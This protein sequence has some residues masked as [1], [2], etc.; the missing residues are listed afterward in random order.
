MTFRCSSAAGSRRT[1]S[2]SAGDR[3]AERELALRGVLRSRARDSRR[4][5]R[6]ARHPV[7]HRYARL[8][9]TVVPLTI[10]GVVTPIATASTGPQFTAPLSWG[11]VDFGD[12]VRYRLDGGACAGT[13][14]QVHVGGGGR[15]DAVGPA[16]QA[17]TDPLATGTCVG[18]A[19]VPSEAQVRATRWAPGDPVTVRIVSV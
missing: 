13:P 16:S 8:A 17:V 2:P 18:I 9:L 14:V 12:Q 15:S 4:R 7:M 19:Q 11:S 5:L 3:A 1:G 6:K 10:I